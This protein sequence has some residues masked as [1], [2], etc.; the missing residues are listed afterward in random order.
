MRSDPDDGS[1]TFDIRAGVVALLVISSM[2][3]V[4][5]GAVANHTENDK[6]CSVDG[7]VRVE[8]RVKH[9]SCQDHPHRGGDTML[10]NGYLQARA[11]ATGWLLAPGEAVIENDETESIQFCTWLLP[12]GCTTPW[13][14]R[15]GD[16]AINPGERRCTRHVDFDG[17]AGPRTVPLAFAGV[18]I[19]AAWKWDSDDSSPHFVGLC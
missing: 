15:P 7:C 18:S 17:E 8:G 4:S 9:G 16:T 13:L 1:L 2:A 5:S 14:S 12:G 6:D 3:I 11:H 19:A 10:C